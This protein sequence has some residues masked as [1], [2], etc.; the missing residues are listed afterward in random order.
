MNLVPL[1]DL[2][3]NLRSNLVPE[4]DLPDFISAKKSPETSTGGA[5]GHGF[6]RGIL[7]A[8]AGIVGGAAA[9]VPGALAGPIGAGAAGL[10]GGAASA[11]GVSALQEEFLRSHPNF[12]KSIGLD[13]EKQ[14]AEAEKHPYA[15]FLGEMAP[16]LVALRPS[17][18]LLKSG[19]GL[20][21][22]EAEK[23]AAE[24]AAALGTGAI[25]AGVG[26]GLEAGQQAIGEEPMD[27]TKVALAGGFGAL[28]QKETAVGKKLVGLGQRPFT[29]V[30]AE[31]EELAKKA[32]REAVDKRAA[33]A[34]KY[35]PEPAGTYA[36]KVNGKEGILEVKEDG[37]QTFNG[38]SIE[39]VSTKDATPISPP[40]ETPK[41]LDATPP[42]PLEQ[43]AKKTLTPEVTGF[44][45]PFEATP[46]EGKKAPLSEEQKAEKANVEALRKDDRRKLREVNKQ[47]RLNKQ[48][49]G[50][51]SLWNAL[52]GTLSDSEIMELDPRPIGIGKDKN[53]YTPLRAKEGYGTDLSTLIADGHLDPFL[54]AEKRAATSLIDRPNELFDET[55]GLEDIRDKLRNNNYLTHD[56]DQGIAMLGHTAQELE[57]NIAKHLTTDE[58]NDLINEA[59]DEQRRLDHEAQ[60]ASTKREAGITEPISNEAAET[61]LL[62][63]YTPDEIRA[64]DAERLRHAEEDAAIT[65]EQADIDKAE[66]IRQE[67]KQR[68]EAA[69]D[70]FEL[71]QTA[72]ENL[73]NQKD[74][75]AEPI[76]IE[77]PERPLTELQKKDLFAKQIGAVSK[78]KGHNLSARVNKKAGKA[79]ANNNFQAV[80]EAL[81]ESKNELVKHIA[82]LAKK[83]KSISTEINSEKSE[84]TSVGRRYADQAAVDSARMHIETIDAMR[85]I[86][87]QVDEGSYSDLAKLM[88]QPMPMF[89]EI[90]S[91][92]YGRPTTANLRQAIEANTGV[93]VFSKESF[94]KAFKIME[95]DTARYGEENLRK[96]AS[97]T[98][99]VEAVLGSYDPSTKTISAAYDRAANDEGVLTHE[100]AHALFHEAI[101]NPTPQ[102]RPAVQRL[103]SL[104]EHVKNEMG[105]AGKETYGLK[106]IH[107]FVSEGV[108]NANFQYQLRNIK[109]E[110][111][112]AWGKF[113]QYLANILGLKNDNA[114]ME[115]ISLTEEL[116]SH[117]NQIG[118]SAEKFEMRGILGKKEEPT[119]APTGAG[120]DAV[121]ILESLNRRA[122]EPDPTH[123][124]KVRQAY[125]TAVDNPSTTKE[126]MKE[127]AKKFVTHMAD[128]IQGMVFSADAPLNNAIRRSIMQ[129]TL[130][131]PE[132][133]KALMSISMSQTVH[134]DAVAS[135]FLHEGD[136]KYDRSISK[137]VAEKSGYNF[138]ALADKLNA[139]AK[140]NGLTVQQ[141]EHAFHTATE[142]RRLKDWITENEKL[143]KQI[144]ES[145]IKLGQLLPK[146]S[147]D[148]GKQIN[149]EAVAS[150]EDLDKSAHFR[151]ATRL[152]KEIKDLRDGKRL[153]HS[154]DPTFKGKPD[155]NV[156]KKQI[157][158]AEQLF[159][160]LPELE[161]AVKDWNGIRK[162]TVKILQETGL[163]TKAEADMMLDNI[164]YVP[165]F[166][167]E[168]LENNAGPKEFLSGMQVKAKEQRASGSYMPVNDIFDNMVRW[169]QYAINRSVR[170][171]SAVNMVDAAVAN[172]LA[173]RI[174][175]PKRDLN[176]VRVWKNGKQEFYHMEDPMFVDAFHGL[177]G[178]SIPTFKAASA[179]TNFLRKSIVLN[180]IFATSQLF[181][182]SFAA[183]FTSGLSPKYALKIPARAVLEYVRTLKGT[184]ETHELLRK[185]GAVGVK[186]FSSTAT[187]MDAE[188]YAGVRPPPG[189]WGKV[190]GIL[191]HISMASDNAVRQAVYQAVMEAKGPGGRSEAI[192]KAF[193]VIN[194]RRRG[195]SR[196]MM[197]GGQLIPFFNAYLAA[198]N[199]AIKTLSGTGIAPSV[200][201]DALK[202]LAATTGS[203]MT[204]SMLYTMLNASD[205]D[206]LKKPATVRDR[207]LV[208]PGSGGFSVPLRPDVFTMPKVIAEHLYLLMTNNATEDSRKFRDSISSAVVTSVS[209]PTM[210]PQVIKPVVEVALNYDFFQSKPLIGVFQ[211]GLDPE[212]QFNEGTSEFSRLVG[213]TG[214][215]SPINMDH[216]IRGWT[217]SL[218]GLFLMLTN[219][220]IHHDPNVQRPTLSWNDWMASVPGNSAFM[221]RD[222]QNGLKKDFYVLKEA[223]DRASATYN[224]I[225]TRTPSEA[226]AYAQV[227]ENRVRIGMHSQI[228]KIGKNLA[229]IRK[230]ISLISN[231]PESQITTDEKDRR[232]KALQAQEDLILKNI[233]IK[234]LRAQAQL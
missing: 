198:Q 100:I 33:E 65:G 210:V 128:R 1:D 137:W 106:S 134:A 227:P 107:E 206:Y 23:L 139:V 82:N 95:E 143:D 135:M 45:E 4:H 41:I 21:K 13:E 67:I 188:I 85:S 73:S 11:A 130:S 66:R 156:V 16:N 222:N 218:G 200:R 44:P 113:T 228:D 22:E 81:S 55:A 147:K 141:A 71:G 217:G 199:V 168:Q 127:N 17:G 151:E 101:D 12:A 103:N 196:I 46:I 203:V 183:I 26:A 165:F 205:E 192:E 133:M 153:I 197:I 186:D 159:K 175:A 158:Q 29:G 118:K 231:M 97:A 155:I 64:R 20:V 27:W 28:G 232:K 136:M 160:K 116:A 207:L 225:K 40:P 142:A 191:E 61:G 176:V 179:M 99:N 187:R 5:F 51:N 194:F 226:A 30:K 36:V 213:Q 109:Y 111:Q 166:R 110:G 25:G 185:T 202:S 145:K 233:D 115:L 87:K 53:P 31:G 154:L 224:D 157:E 124:E 122:P 38:Q 78:Y 117:P 150:K 234:K 93:N 50:P 219:P 72:E 114:F 96:N 173:Y 94:D 215:I 77:T 132:K 32:V 88:D 167:E 48:N 164:N 83:L 70:T 189:G 54:P 123:L 174:P 3:E 37:S 209:A 178:V 172:D 89:S 98:I 146:A 131:M 15:S 163:W 170:N 62:E 129:S 152:V 120:A 212:R 108:S 211:K 193:E 208:V 43:P 177:E 220:L 80:V 18:A 69:A 6:V 229:Q 204:L 121:N 76:K 125:Q 49:K 119:P 91:R 59:A 8:A 35:E 58:I 148:L 112:T 56:A 169:T 181:Q 39:P 19:K 216:L 10:V 184:S 221:S 75:F 230:N 201:K 105:E 190:K 182:D 92:S 149:L 24:K 138:K 86:K 102:Q 9:A 223:V 14:R 7:P 214:L 74:I 47:I 2:P 126:A 60:A 63:S 104:Y 161:D 90:L 195:S 180:P 52:R 140:A 84:T 144:F 34:P 171:Q 57:E 79:L 162:N 42:K 68:S